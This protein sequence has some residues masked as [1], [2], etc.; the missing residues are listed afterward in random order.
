MNLVSEKSKII[1]A[2]YF[3]A[4]CEWVISQLQNY[5]E[6]LADIFSD[7]PSSESY[8]RFCFA[9]LKI[10]KTS[11]EK[12]IQAIELGKVDYRDLLVSAG[13]ANSLTIHNNW[14]DKV[15]EAET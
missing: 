6:Y 14:A 12:L 15:L 9:V 3:P 5:C 13:F 10:G 4:D 1:T 7:D 2:K 11:K 8:E